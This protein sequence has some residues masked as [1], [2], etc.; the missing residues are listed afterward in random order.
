MGKFF[1]IYL[2]GFYCRIYF[3]FFF[4]EQKKEKGCEKMTSLTFNFHILKK[5][6]ILRN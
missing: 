3:F 6:I 1:H 2:L 5:G 4:L